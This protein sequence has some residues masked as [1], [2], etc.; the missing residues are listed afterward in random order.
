MWALFYKAKGPV[1]LVISVSVW[2]QP[3]GQRSMYSEVFS[4]H[5]SQRIS[6]L[7]PVSL[8]LGS[9]IWQVIVEVWGS[10]A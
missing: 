4:S 10:I 2:N 9:N 5:R 8:I 7:L 6:W 3:V 1:R